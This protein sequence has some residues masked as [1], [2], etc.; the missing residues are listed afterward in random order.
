MLDSSPNRRAIGK[1]IKLY[2]NCQS[3]AYKERWHPEGMTERLDKMQRKGKNKNA[4]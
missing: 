1:E 3:L 2:A 4:P